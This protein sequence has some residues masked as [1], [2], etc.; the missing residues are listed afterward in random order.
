M[1]F[2]KECLGE[3]LRRLSGYGIDGVIIGSTAYQLRLGWKDLQDDVDVF[4][5]SFSPSFDEDLILSA[6]EDL[7]CFVGRTSWETPQLRCAV[8]GCEIILEF[9]ENIYDFY[10]PD[11]IVKGAEK[12]SLKGFTAKVIRVEDYVVLKAK[13]GRDKDL[14][15][16]RFIGDLMKAGKL[17]LS[18]D[19]ILNR[20][21]L[22][23]P[24]DRRFMIR[25]LFE[26]EIIK[27]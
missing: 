5:T 23:D 6:A 1:S 9:Y 10:V 11:E 8:D 19:V 3:L 16:L 13:A 27:K 21:E 24:E 2:G 22:F 20:V 15:D 18:K 14:E 17:R 7:S 26:A 4:A 25:K 12:L